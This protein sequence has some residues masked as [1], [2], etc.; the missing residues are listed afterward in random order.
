MKMLLFYYRGFWNVL[1]PLIIN[2]AKNKNIPTRKLSY[3]KDDLAMRPIYGCPENF[4]LSLST[5]TLLF[6]IFLMLFCSDRSCECVNK[7]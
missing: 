2:G 1:A 5:P 7:I 4:Q 3:R 6:R